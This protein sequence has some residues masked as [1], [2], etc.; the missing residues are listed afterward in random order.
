MSYFHSYS[1]Y[2]Y[3]QNFIFGYKEVGKGLR[4]E[5]LAKPKATPKDIDWYRYVRAE[6]D[7]LLIDTYYG[8]G[9]DWERATGKEWFWK[10]HGRK[11]TNSYSAQDLKFC[12]IPR[13]RTAWNLL[14][15]A[16]QRTRS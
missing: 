14:Y 2:S 7:E 6:E 5:T 10:W 16:A 13:T 4:M 15:W 9:V 11:D 1:P 3:Y 8:R 12:R